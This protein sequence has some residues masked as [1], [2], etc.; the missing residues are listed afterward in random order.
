MAI[1]IRDVVQEDKERALW[2][3]KYALANVIYL[4][5]VWDWFT[6]QNDG[7]FIGALLDD[8]LAGFGKITRLFDD[9]GW[10]ETL[11]IHPDYQ[12]KGLGD[13]IYV[14]YLHRAKQ[15]GLNKIGLFTEWDNYRSFNL[16]CK[17][18]FKKYG[19]Y[20]DYSLAVN[21]NDYYNG[22]FSLIDE[23]NSETIISTY[24][25]KMNRFVILNKTFFPV[26]EGLGKNLA[27]RKWAYMDD[28]NNFAIIGY[29]MTPYKATYLAYYDGDFN[30]IL[31]FTNHIALKN[32]SK[33][34]S[35]IREK[36]DPIV[37]K[38]ETNGFKNV[39]DFMCLYKDLD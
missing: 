14:E 1:I 13:A 30:K 31:S 16:A 20:A 10:L 4:N 33:R 18:G 27:Q 5:D 24:Y 39:E 2:I 12:G 6:S 28:D 34:I 3:E 21:E 25:N 17:Y 38:L 35:A 7:Y 8:E 23:E 26:I 19:N 9:V 37:K 36:V 22:S 11:R 32:G 29:R 15:L